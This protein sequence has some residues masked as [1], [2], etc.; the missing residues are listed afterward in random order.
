MAGWTPWTQDE[1]DYIRLELA[2]NVLRMERLQMGNGKTFERREQTFGDLAH[3]QRGRPMSRQLDLRFGSYLLYGDEE[4]QRTFQHF[5][6]LQRQFPGWPV[7]LIWPD[8]TVMHGIILDHNAD[9]VSDCQ[10]DLV[11]N[12]AIL[13]E[14]PQ[15]KVMVI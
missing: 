4:R 3:K 5:L 13:R 11:I 7:T 10:G 1:P 15:G 12:F 6:L 9:E 14:Y 2:G 8:K